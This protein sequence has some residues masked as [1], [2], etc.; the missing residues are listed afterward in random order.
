MSHFG[1]LS[2]KGTGHLNSLAALSRQL[3]SRGHRITFFQEPGLETQVRQY[4]LEFS[5]IG[6]THDPVGEPSGTN[7]QR[8]S[9]SGIADLRYRIK[10]ITDE[11]EIYLREAP[12]ALTRAGINA[13]IVVEIALPRPTLAQ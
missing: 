3:V 2:Y 5:P 13:L 4:G 1:V 7:N 6:K 11:I 9:M 10:R 12:D 8:R